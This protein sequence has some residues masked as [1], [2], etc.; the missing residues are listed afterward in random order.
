LVSLSAVAKQIA[1]TL[2]RQLVKE[3]VDLN[4]ELKENQ[5]YPE[6]KFNKLGDVDY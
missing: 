2:N 4:F 6:L 5:S 1:E 3:L